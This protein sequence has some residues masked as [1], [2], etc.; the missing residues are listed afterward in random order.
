M[1]IKHFVRICFAI[2]VTCIILGHPTYASA[3]DFYFPKVRIE[4]AIFTDGSFVIDEYRTYAFEGSFSWASLNIPLRVNRQG[5]TYALELEEF[6]VLDEHGNPLRTEIT[7]DRRRFEAKW[8]YSARNEQRT[9]HIHYRIRQ[10]L[11][12]YPT[13]PSCTGRS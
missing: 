10:G 8:Y 9:F 1:K 2:S 6:K 13:Y 12:S 3:K 7:S 4:V 5:V 11:F